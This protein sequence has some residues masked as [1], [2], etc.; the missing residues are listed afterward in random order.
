[1]INVLIV[2]DSALVRSMLSKL[3]K[4]DSRF[5]LCGTAENGLKAIQMNEEFSPDLI[6]MDVNMPV[7]D[8]VEAS[9]K[10]MNSNKRAAIVVFT[11]EDTAHI[12][13]KCLEAGVREIVAKPNLMTMTKKMLEEFCDR[14]FYIGNGWKKTFGKND[15]HE[16]VI[17]IPME[18]P[19][20]ISFTNR[21]KEYN[22]VSIGAST[23]GPA[24]IQT[25]LKN[26]G[27]NFSLPI[28]ITQHND[29]IFD[30]QF[31]RW[32][33]TT[34]GIETKLAETGD[35][36]ENGK[37]Y[38]APANYHLTVEKTTDRKFRIILNDDAPIHFLKPAVD[39][40][41][42]NL[43]KVNGDKTIAVLLTGMGQDGA[44]GMKDIY[45][46]GGLTIVQDERSCTVFGMPKA[47]I[48]LMAA[49]KILSLNEIGSFIKAAVEGGPQK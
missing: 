46:K 18:N 5:N 39:K 49:K 12:A 25:V 6:V 41:F 26:I 23:G 9:K 13:F 1:M 11:T 27:K 32:L 7:M 15:F 2:D 24:A 17:E 4:D 30:S 16:P 36:L 3:I 45:T 48:D 38:I 22:L 33:N 31:V 44:L 10:I 8:G 14:L 34:T 20:N 40:M 42:M 37:V 43:A 28:L 21:K 29:A 19:E 47:A 35:I